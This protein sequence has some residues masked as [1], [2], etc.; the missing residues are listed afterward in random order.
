M[1]IKTLPHSSGDA[2]SSSRDTTRLE[3]IGLR[4]RSRVVALKPPRKSIEDAGTDRWLSPR[5]VTAMFSISEATLY[6][7]VKQRPEFPRPVKLS[8]GCTR[9]SLKQLQDFAAG[10]AV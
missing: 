8:P 3:A 10:G 2:A 5:Q 7:W 4:D 9:F 1:S 6:R